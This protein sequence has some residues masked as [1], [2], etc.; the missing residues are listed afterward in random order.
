MKRLVLLGFLLV[1]CKDQG[2]C[3]TEIIEAEYGSFYYDIQLRLIATYEEQGYDCDS[4]SIRNGAGTRIGTK[5]T[6]TK[7]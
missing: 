2:P 4:E 7:C 3:E 1:A 5:Y 6:C